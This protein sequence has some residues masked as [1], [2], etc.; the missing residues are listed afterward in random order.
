KQTIIAK[1]ER[2]RRTTESNIEVKAMKEKYARVNSGRPLKKAELFQLAEREQEKK[3][4][5]QSINK[6]DVE[7]LEKKTLEIR[8]E[9]EKNDPDMK[10]V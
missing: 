1:Y 7:E 4:V 2:Q 10:N 3:I 9:L 6:D 5:L 8:E